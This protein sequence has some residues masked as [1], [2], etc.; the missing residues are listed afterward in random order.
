MGLRKAALFAAALAL[1]LLGCRSGDSG[2]YVPPASPYTP[3]DFVWQGDVLTCTKGN[4]RH[5]IDV[6]SHQGEIDW[7][8]VADSGVDFAFIRLGYR[9]YNS[10]TLHTDEYAGANLRGAGNAGLKVGA[11][12]FSQAV[13][14]EEAREEAAYAL[15]ILDGFPL[16]LPLM[17]DWEF[18]SLEAR[19]GRVTG[20]TLT[21]CTQAFC[22]VIEENGLAPAVYFNTDQ[23]QKLSLEALPYPW[24]L[25]KYNEDLDFV[26]QVDLW[27]YS[28]TGTVPGIAGNV[29]L[30][31]M[32]TD[33]GLGK[34]VF[35]Q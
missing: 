28:N 29:D 21:E 23:A 33:Y 20:E 8:Q 25:A 27:Q 31:L 18:V 11:Y 2:G 35:G 15:D 32:F 4:V 26:C 14:V 12:F 22:R 5:G 24:W 17:Y 6:S 16:D 30:D 1:L 3:A 9:G 13:S 10:G 19:T 34:E 7:Q